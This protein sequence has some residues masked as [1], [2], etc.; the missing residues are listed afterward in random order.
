VSSLTRQ[1]IVAELNRVFA[2]EVEAA[3]RYL[4][5]CSA[6]RGLDRLLVERV[7]KEGFQETI[8]HAEVIAQKIRSLGHVPKLDIRVQ[9]SSEPLSGREALRQA[10]TFEEAALECYQD[11]LRR[12]EGDVPLEEFIRSQIAVESE[13]VAQLRELLAE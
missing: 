3:T 9:C 8:Q 7:L 13:H 12:V 6:V 1:E 11:L 10:L 5:L 2:E 4:H